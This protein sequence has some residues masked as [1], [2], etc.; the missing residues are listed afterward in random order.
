MKQIPLTQGQFAMVDDNDYDYLM[1]WRWCAVFC[2][3]GKRFYAARSHNSNGKK[4]TISMHRQL[5]GITDKHTIVDHKDH[6][7]L[8]NS[9]VN[10]RIVS[11][12]ENMANRLPKIN[13]SSNFLGVYKFKNKNY[14][15]AQITKGG[16]QKY[17][18]FFYNEIEAAKAYDSAALEIH[19][20]FANTNFKNGDC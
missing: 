18:G 19:G 7:A 8:N 2:K 10:L 11:H 14:W 5:L 20:E 9:R 12:A 3:R 6:N 4:N 15:S 13:G 16:K 1:Q 17:L